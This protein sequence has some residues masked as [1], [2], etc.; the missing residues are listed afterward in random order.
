M[1]INPVPFLF[2][3]GAALLGYWVSGGHGAAIGLSAWGALV[4]TATYISLR[5]RK[6]APERMTGS[7]G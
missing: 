7:D 3:P 5:L 1:R 2:A 4:G 6:H